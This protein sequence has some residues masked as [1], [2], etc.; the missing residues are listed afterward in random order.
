MSISKKFSGLETESIYSAAN[1]AIWHSHNYACQNAISN[2]REEDFV[3]ALITD[4]VPLL[5]ER[6]GSLLAKKGMSLRI[7][8]VFCHGHPQVKF[9]PPPNR[10]ELADLLVVHQHIGRSKSFTRAILV[11]AKMSTDATLR[12]SPT[13]CQLQLFSTWPDF[14]FVTGGLKKGLRNFGNNKAGSRYSLILPHQSYP[15]QITWPDQCPWSASVAQTMLEGEH[16][17]AKLLGNLLLHKDGRPVSLVSP[18][19]DW[20]KTVKEL[21]VITGSKT[22]RRKNIGRISTPR[23]TYSNDILANVLFSSDSFASYLCNSNMENQVV[24]IQQLMF[25]NIKEE[26]NDFGFEPPHNERLHDG[27]EPRGISTLIIESSDLD[28]RYEQ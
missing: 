18:R 15:E 3:A 26:S 17:F 28:E 27:G 24:P 2:P 22:Y 12:L 8:G 20:S 1:S 6:W 13:D 14:E 10:V 21:L 7:S 5:S 25:K 19:G 11:Q 4:G 9:D 23:G 16:S